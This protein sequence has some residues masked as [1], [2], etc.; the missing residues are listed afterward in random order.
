MAFC[1]IRARIGAA[2]MLF[3]QTPPA[4]LKSQ[5]KLQKDAVMSLVLK[6]GTSLT[7]EEKGNLAALAGAARFTEEDTLAI[8]S[9]LEKDSEKQKPKAKTVYHDFREF[10]HYLN[11]DE[12][13][14][15]GQSVD[16]AVNV[17]ISVLIYKLRCLHAD[18]HTLKRVAATA[19]CHTSMDN[20]ASAPTMAANVQNTVKTQ[21]HKAQRKAK[22]ENKKLEPMPD[23]PLVL[24]HPN[25]LRRMFSEY[26]GSIKESYE[27]WVPPPQTVASNRVFLVDSLMSC[28]GGSNNPLAAS[29]A[30]SNGPSAGLMHSGGAQMLQYLVQKV[31][32]SMGGNRRYRHEEPEISIDYSGGSQSRKRSLK[33]FLES[34]S[35]HPTAWKRASTLPEP[36]DQ[37][38]QR[39]HQAANAANLGIQADPPGGLSAAA[40]AAAATAAATVAPPAPEKSSSETAAAKPE[41]VEGYQGG[42]GNLPLTRGQLLMQAYQERQKSKRAAQPAPKKKV[43]DAKQK[44]NECHKGKAGNKGKNGSLP[45]LPTQISRRKNRIEHEMSRSQYLARGADGSKQ[46]RYGK[47]EP[48]TDAAKAKVAAQKWMKAQA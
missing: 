32:E 19:I 35:G 5:S 26:A 20:L 6:E 42:A 1:Q 45:T 23:I 12:W 8:L 14:M 21:Y 28:R 41:V 11:Q 27:N 25:L 31:A 16:S 3:E 18:E 48:Y 15:A 29:L 2:K 40:T 9:A 30:L 38:L 24:V 33:D 47:G 17:F 10:V 44:A 22:L 39:Q 13:A 37:G 46:F 36:N 43:K 4:L 34:D 7:A